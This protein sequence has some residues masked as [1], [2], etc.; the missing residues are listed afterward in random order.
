MTKQ[1]TIRVHKKFFSD[2]ACPNCFSVAFNLACINIKTNLAKRAARGRRFLSFAPFQKFRV[3]VRRYLQLEPEPELLPMPLQ[4]LEPR[5]LVREPLVQL[6]LQQEQKREQE[7]LLELPEP[8]LVQLLV[9][10]EQEFPLELLELELELVQL[11]LLVRVPQLGFLVVVE[12][13]PVLLPVLVRHFPL[14]REQRRR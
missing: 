10:Q 4:L 13:E 14:V 6:Q 7:L 9:Q 8:A 11:P 5:G 12:P 3:S 1:K 2:A